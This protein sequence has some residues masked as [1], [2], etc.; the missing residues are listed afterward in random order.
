MDYSYR[1]NLPPTAI[2]GAADD[3]NTFDHLSPKVG[4]NY[5]LSSE[6]GFYGNYSEGFAPPLFS[7][8]YKAVIVPVLKPASYSNYELGGWL[9]F[10]D[11]R[12][13]LDL[14]IYHSNGTNEIVSVLLGDGTSQNQST[15]ETVHKG[16]EY[17]VRYLFFDQLEA[18]LNAANSIHKYLEFV[19]QD[20]D[21]SGNYMSL[22]PKFVANTEVTWRP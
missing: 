12:G 5:N 13:Y 21:Y 17:S 20:K 15:G 3:N 4:I 11:T 19:Y 2:S 16:I 14:S 8:L 1:N 22:A 10:S 6:I 7:Q 9:S 18:R